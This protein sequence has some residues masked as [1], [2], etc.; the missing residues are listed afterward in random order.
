MCDEKVGCKNVGWKNKGFF[1]TN[2][3]YPTENGF[4]I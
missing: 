2:E 3:D 1:L 4:S